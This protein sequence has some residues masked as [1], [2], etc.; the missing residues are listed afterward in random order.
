MMLTFKINIYI[1]L[2]LTLLNVAAIERK[3]NE[4]EGQ[5]IIAFHTFLR[6]KNTR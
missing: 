6:Q 3:L 4:N 2:T 1:L 5:R